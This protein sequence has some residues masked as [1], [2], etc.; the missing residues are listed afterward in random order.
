MGRDSKRHQLA[1]RLV[2]GL[3]GAALLVLAAGLW[4]PPTD[5]GGPAGKLPAQ[6]EKDEDLVGA[7][8]GGLAGAAEATSYESELGIVEEAARVLEAHESAGDCI[9]AEAGYLD[10]SGR[11]WGCVLQGSGWVEICVV[12]EQTDGSGSEVG[13]WR[14]DADDAERALVPSGPGDSP[15]SST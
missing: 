3:V 5:G 1:L 8:L 10:L 13:V 2:A 14:M 12:S 6:G 7:S 15:P 9:V 4:A 11:T